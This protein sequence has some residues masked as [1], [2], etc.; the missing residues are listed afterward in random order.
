LSETEAVEI[1]TSIQTS[2][3]GG[4]GALSTLIEKES[5]VSALN[6]GAI[7]GHGIDILRNDTI[8][9]ATALVAAVPV[10][11][12]SPFALDGEKYMCTNY[13]LIPGEIQSGRTENSEE[14]PKGVQESRRYLSR[15][16]LRLFA[17]CSV[18]HLRD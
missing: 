2:T 1:I 17:E 8:D 13:K 14:I 12:P 7:V 3:K 11:S 15:L 18:V 9:Y 6:L 5:A 10:N 4:I 16:S